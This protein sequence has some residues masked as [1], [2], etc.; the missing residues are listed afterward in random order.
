MEKE[1]KL[2]ELD[3]DEYQIAKSKVKSLIFSAKTI[4]VGIYGKAEKETV[5]PQE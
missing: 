4:S 3:L 5:Y 1:D 2:Q